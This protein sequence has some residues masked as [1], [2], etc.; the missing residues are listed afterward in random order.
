MRIAY[1][2][3]DPGVPP[4]G[5]K[6][7]SI[8]VQEIIRAM[9]RV[10]A[11]VDLFTRRLDG[12]APKSLTHVRV[13]TLPDAAQSAE[14]ETELL[15]GNVELRNQL[16]LGAYDFVYE[17]YSL[18][19]YAGMEFARACGLPGVLEV[20][21]PLIEEQATYRGL[22][23]RDAVE[24]VT[25]RAFSAA[26]LLVAVSDEVA[27]YL[28]TFP[29]ARGKIAVIP[30]AIDPERF[31]AQL[32][33]SL[34]AGDGIFTVGFVG[35]LRPWHGLSLLASAFAEFA[36]QYPQSRLVIVGDG[37][38]RELLMAQLEDFGLR[39]RAVFTGSVSPDRIPSLIASMDVAVAPY[40]PLDHF[41]F[42]PLKVFEYMAAGRAIVAS[43]IGQI[44]KIIE[45]N[46]T[47]WLVAPGDVAALAEALRTLHDQ[48]DLRR[49]LGAQARDCVLGQHTWEQNV[50]KVLSLVL[51][52]PAVSAPAKS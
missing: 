3:A 44:E 32:H 22:V 40:P 10:G 4:F 41:Y 11:Q 52:E 37:P 17:R 1:V 20:N 12:A 23:N 42:S 5:T 8:H 13:H 6:G 24:E 49:R 46:D 28:Q 15:A 50:R 43:R 33:P 26:T 35:T 7:C 27:A 45:H 14:R 2:N 25:R 51:Q 16:A 47:G 34:P 18:W 9:L 38:E 21:A 29:E 30:N 36:P 19:C 39:E 48:P 31:P